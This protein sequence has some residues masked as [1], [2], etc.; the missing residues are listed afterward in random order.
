VV[1]YLRSG[2]IRPRADSRWFARAPEP[3][4]APAEAVDLLP[5]GWP[6]AG[7]AEPLHQLPETWDDEQDWESFARLWGRWEPESELTDR[8]YWE[9]VCALVL[10]WLADP[11]PPINAITI[12]AYACACADATAA[13]AAGFRWDAA[14]WA[15]RAAEMDDA[16]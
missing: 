11:P 7:D 6:A 8:Q 9:Q 1:E 14:V 15:A 10:G 13:V 4:A 5:E 12:V 3:A 2:A 16:S